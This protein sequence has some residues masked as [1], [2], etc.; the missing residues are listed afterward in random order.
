[1]RACGR[2]LLGHKFV[3][4][5]YKRFRKIASANTGL[6]CHNNHREPSFIQPANRIGDMRQDT[7]SADMIQVSDFFGNGAV[8]IKKNGGTERAGIQAGRTSLLDIQ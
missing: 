2:E 6:I 5:V 3:N 4:R 7:K 1:M 8:T